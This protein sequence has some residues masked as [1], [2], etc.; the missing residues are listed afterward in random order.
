MFVRLGFS[1]VAVVVVDMAAFSAVTELVLLLRFAIV[2]LAPY[3][4]GVG[5]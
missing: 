5:G 3:R 4:V 1:S 2:V